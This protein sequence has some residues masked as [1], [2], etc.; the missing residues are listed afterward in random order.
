M[1]QQ[2]ANDDPG[3][4]KFLGY[5]YKSCIG[6]LLKPFQELPESKSISGAS[7]RLSAQWVLYLMAHANPTLSLSRQNTNLFVD[8]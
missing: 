6:F 7:L 5:F 2:R 8:A 1:P 3:I 4:K